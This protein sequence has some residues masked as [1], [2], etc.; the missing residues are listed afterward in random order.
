MII[1]RYN[2]TAFSRKKGNSQTAA[3]ARVSSSVSW[4]D[5]CVKQIFEIT[6]LA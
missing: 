4:A 6:L 3:P 1:G 2:K 5:G